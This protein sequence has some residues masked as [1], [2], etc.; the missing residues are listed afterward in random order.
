[1]AFELQFIIRPSFQ[2]HR[3]KIVMCAFVSAGNEWSE[4]NLYRVWLPQPLYMENMFAKDTWKFSG[5][6]LK[7]RQT[8]PAYIRVAV[9]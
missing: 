5:Y 6:N 9:K 7:K 8:V 2:V 4:N 3:E 1:M